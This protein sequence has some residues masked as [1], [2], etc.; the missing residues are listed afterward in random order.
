MSAQPSGRKRGASLPVRRRPRV[1]G[2]GSG[3]A[4]LGL[5]LALAACASGPDPIEVAPTLD[6][7]REALE[8]GEAEVALRVVQEVRERDGESTEG[9]CLEARA[10]RTLRRYRAALAALDRIDP[11]AAAM[12][13]VVLDRV[14][15]LLEY[16]LPSEAL[17]RLESL[18][19]SVEEEP[20]A[21]MVYRRGELH[22][23]M[24]MTDEA[25]VDFR[26][27]RVLQPEWWEPLCAEAATLILEKRFKEARQQLD[28]ARELTIQH[29]ELAH[30]RALVAEAE[31]EP[32]LALDWYAR[33]LEVDVQHWPSHLNQ[34]VLLEERGLRDQAM[35]AFQRV[36]EY[37]PARDI[38][39]RRAIVEK[40]KEL[41]G[42]A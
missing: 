12:P 22:N 25:L 1:C 29:P 41:R 18:M 32:E 27:A 40:V 15:T 21:E 28:D 11:A 24:G 30:H 14:D 35:H 9:W 19:A 5:V 39:R 4:V 37:L 16:G 3:V 36:L 26:H 6:G 7:V 33:A 8:Q 17:D 10:L 31:Q 23:S 34:A 38:Y 13:S 2:R 42:G 20:S